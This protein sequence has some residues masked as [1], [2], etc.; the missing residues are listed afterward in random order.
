MPWGTGAPRSS[1]PRAREAA[2]CDGTRIATS[3]ANSSATP[4]RSPRSW[5]PSRLPAATRK[6]WRSSGPKRCSRE[7]R[8]LP[9]G[10]ACPS[11]GR[12]R[13]REGGKLHRFGVEPDRV[14]G[15]S[16]AGEPEHRRRAY[17]FLEADRG[18]MPVKRNGLAQTSFRR[19][20]LGYRET[21]RQGLHRT[22]LGVPNFRVLTVTTSEERMRHLIEAGRSLSGSAGTFLFGQQQGLAS[23]DLPNYEWLDGRGSRTIL[24]TA[25][26]HN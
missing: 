6:A 22:H 16:F 17:F 10:C 19:K 4:S 21:W 14:F 13:S 26:D 2:P 7:R 18:T 11:A 12:L 8:K 25:N 3:L 5:S 23:L 24:F 1:P 20:L 9:G 15:L